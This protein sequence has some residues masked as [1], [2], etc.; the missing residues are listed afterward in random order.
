V[1]LRIKGLR[2]SLTVFVVAV[3]I[4]GCS[5]QENAEV[6]DNESSQ[7][8]K[9]DN[10]GED[11]DSAEKP[12]AK[13][14]AADT[15]YT[16]GKIYTVHEKQP[17][18]EAV[19]IKDGKFIKVGSEDDVKPLIGDATETH[20]LGGQLVLP[21][22]VEPHTH[23][24]EDFHKQ[25]FQLKLDTSSQEN[26]LKS[27]K[28]YAEANSDKE[29]I[30]GGMWP[31][32][33]FPGNSPDRKLLDEVVPDRPV[34]LIDQSAHSCW[35]NTKALEL[36]GLMKVDVEL[37][38][39][40]V[41]ER[42]EDGKPSGTIREYAIGYVRRFMPPFPLNE[43]AETG[44]HVQ[45]VFHELGFT[46]TRVAAV[47][48]DHL[49]AMKSLD[50]KGE[51]KLRL[52][53]AMPENYFDSATSSEEQMALIGR[54][55]KYATKH[56]HP[57]A[58]K[59]WTDGTQVE[60][61]AWLTKKYP[62]TDSVG[63]AYFTPEQLVEKHIK[64]QKMGKSV[65][66]HACG[67]RAVHEVLNAIAA[68]KKALPDSKVRHQPTHC[69][70]ISPDDLPRFAKLGVAAEFSPQF[71]FAPGFLDSMIQTLGRESVEAMYPA[72]DVLDAGGVVAIGSDY[73]VTPL[74]PWSKIQWLVR[75][76]HPD[77]PTM[78]VLA[79][80]RRLSVAEA[81]RAYTFG[82]AYAIGRDHEV[83]TIEVGK[84]ADFIVLSQD[85]FDLEEAKRTDLIGKTRPTKTIFEGEIV[86]DV[87]F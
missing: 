19:A 36:A 76:Q 12:K 14:E 56:V 50:D 60:K 77:H 5:P 29:W 44:R 24:L 79:P 75:H 80:N 30:V 53:F 21:G 40:A 43:W 81:I 16:G 62:G 20:D 37:P 6:A 55:D 3:F 4:S 47:A 59:L 7:A 31:I 64:Y 23:P 66:S 74:D 68:A 57:D 13:E 11:K 27:V 52:S 83:G 65:M 72:R 48:E 15:V 84:Y 8:E 10:S 67:D 18:A 61:G 63:T 54:S 42:D 39:G 58:V 46:S 45:T 85:L 22:F 82:G 26:L 71:M 69:I 86:F 2:F 35:V 17:W 25:L 1:K 73:A 32:G 78:E 34:F 38:K 70:Q 51:L 33:M 9:Q 49:K 28:D 41:V 87:G